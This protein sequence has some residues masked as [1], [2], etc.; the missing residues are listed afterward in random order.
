[1]KRLTV[2]FVAVT[3]AGILGCGGGTMPDSAHKR[4]IS[5]AGLAL[6][7][8]CLDPS[9]DEAVIEDQVTTLLREADEAGDTRFTLSEGLRQVTMGDI[10][11]GRVA[12]MRQMRCAPDQAKRLER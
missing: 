7:A 11:Q 8:E 5:D 9:P 1:M 10:L 3:T 4:A 12:F 2:I 6:A